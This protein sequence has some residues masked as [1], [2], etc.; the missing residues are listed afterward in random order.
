MPRYWNWPGSGS[1]RTRPLHTADLRSLLPFPDA[2]FDDV[3]ASLVVHYLERRA[4]NWA[5][6][7]LSLEL[8]V[9]G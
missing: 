4:V 1:A 8:L 9:G 3:V 5:S 2:A 7:L 6:M